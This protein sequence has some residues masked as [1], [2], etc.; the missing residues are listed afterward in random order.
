MASGYSGAKVWSSDL[1]FINDVTSLKQEFI[2]ADFDGDHNRKIKALSNLNLLIQPTVDV[3]D[4]LKEIYWL[5]DNALGLIN[6]INKQGQQGVNYE[7]ARKVNRQM[8]FIMDKML[9]KLQE[10]G[11][12]TQKPL[13]PKKSMQDFSSS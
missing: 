11:R 1:Q 7:N 6:V 4:E 3:T 5:E 12:Y 13:D 8:R 2:N 9:G 10:G